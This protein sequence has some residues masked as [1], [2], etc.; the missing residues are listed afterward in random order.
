MKCKI[1]IYSFIFY[2][3]FIISASLV[4]DNV[5]RPPNIPG[6]EYGYGPGHRVQIEPLPHPARIE[7]VQPPVAVCEGLPFNV[8]PTLDIVT[9]DVCQET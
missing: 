8:Q 5:Y 4:P 9:M 1:I 3:S 2:S 7:I 6:Y